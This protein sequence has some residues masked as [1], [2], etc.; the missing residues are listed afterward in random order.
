MMLHDRL[1]EGMIQA[2]L[3]R[4]RAS[5]GQ[6]LFIAGGAQGVQG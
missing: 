1:A 3:P 6:R 4:Q 2:L 5:S